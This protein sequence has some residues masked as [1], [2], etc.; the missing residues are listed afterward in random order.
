MDKIKCIICDTEIEA[1]DYN[2]IVIDKTNEI[3][4]ICDLCIKKTILGWIVA[5]RAPELQRNA[6]EGRKKM[7]ET[8]LNI[9]GD[10]LYDD[11]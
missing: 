9:K 3:A 10:T 6:M 7:K 5:L 11:K 2:H 1:N 4:G 8:D